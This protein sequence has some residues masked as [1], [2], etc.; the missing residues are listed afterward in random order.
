M[1]CTVSK[2]P[3]SPSLSLYLS[4]YHAFY[5]CLE[6]TCTQDCTC[7]YQLCRLLSSLAAQRESVFV[8]LILD[9]FPS[10]SRSLMEWALLNIGSKFLPNEEQ[11]SLHTNRQTE[12]IYYNIIILVTMFN[13]GGRA[14]SLPRSNDTRDVATQLFYSAVLLKRSYYSH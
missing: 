14:K 2:A 13:I 10:F 12:D 3:L 7:T 5:I 1:T 8:R 9:F 4:L 11:R 6:P